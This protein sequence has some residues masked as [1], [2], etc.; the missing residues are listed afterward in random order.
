M[1]DMV[2]DGYSVSRICEVLTLEGVKTPSEYKKMRCGQKNLHIGVWNARTVTDILKNP[3]YMG[4]LTQSRSKKINYKSKKRVHQTRNNWIIS[5]D[6]CPAIVSKDKFMMVQN[7]FNSNKFRKSEGITSKLLLRGLIYCK[8]CQHT[9]GFR[10]HKQNTKSSGEVFRIY[11]NCNY[12]AK[13]K[14]EKV[15]SPHSVKY[16]DILDIVLNDLKR[17]F[18]KLNIDTLVSFVKENN[19]CNKKIFDVEKNICNVEKDIFSLRN[20]IDMIYNDKLEG[21][22]D[23]FMYKRMYEKL[24]LDIKNRI[25]YKEKLLKG[26]KKLEKI[27]YDDKFYMNKISE[28]LDINNI[29]RNM[30]A[31]LIERIEISEDKNIAIYYKFKL[32]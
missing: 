10:A 19:D 18:K 25:D 21:V 26:K 7:I 3:T 1:F 11:G 17:I 13:R 9:I 14:K 5:E 29:S 8:E 24:T 4:N 6:S 23:T 15:C 2:L 30:I 20:K 27:T 12:W 31:G 22:I 32:D 28:F 16:E